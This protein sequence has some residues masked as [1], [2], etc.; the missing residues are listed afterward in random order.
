MEIISDNVKEY[1]F[2]SLVL[3]THIFLKLKNMATVD[4]NLDC[5]RELSSEQGERVEWSALVKGKALLWDVLF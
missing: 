3:T 4:L 2:E 5:L 1:L